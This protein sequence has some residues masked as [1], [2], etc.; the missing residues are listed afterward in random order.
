MEIIGMLT[1]R[2][3]SVKYRVLTRRWAAKLEVRKQ[4][5]LRWLLELGF[6]PTPSISFWC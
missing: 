6:S 1:L 2:N 5:R 3:T 4:T